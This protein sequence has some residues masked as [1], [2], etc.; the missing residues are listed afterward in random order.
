MSSVI[1]KVLQL[2]NRQAKRILCPRG[3]VEDE[4]N[5]A[6]LK[7]ESG[8]LGGRKFS[9]ICHAP[10]VCFDLSTPPKAKLFICFDLLGSEKRGWAY[11]TLSPN[12]K[13]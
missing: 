10:V 12:P 13:P 8:G 2:F 11:K 6:S 5:V 7:R 9:T 4:S 1:G 3:R